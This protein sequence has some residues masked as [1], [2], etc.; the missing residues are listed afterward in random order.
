MNILEYPLPRKTEVEK[1]S[2]LKQDNGGGT[3]RRMAWWRKSNRIIEFGYENI[4]VFLK[5]N[6]LKTW[7]A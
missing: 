1:I 5:N 4:A 3:E 7:W 6:R 2:T